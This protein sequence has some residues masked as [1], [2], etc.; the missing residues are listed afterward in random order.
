MKFFRDLKENQRNVSLWYMREGKML[1]ER[2]TQDYASQPSHA[3]IFNQKFKLENIIE[4]M[5]KIPILIAPADPALVAIL[6]PR[7]HANVQTCE[8]TSA[9]FQLV[10]NLRV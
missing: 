7:P 3:Q 2:L 4:I 9:K 8:D 6:S 5:K 1:Y 10:R